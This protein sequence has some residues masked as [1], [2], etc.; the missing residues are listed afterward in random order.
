[1]PKKWH[2][3][4]CNAET[5]TE[6]CFRCGGHGHRSGNVNDPRDCSWCSGFGVICGAC[7][8]AFNK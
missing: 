7:E 1:M 2:R 8:K 5:W 4:G 3:G 6:K